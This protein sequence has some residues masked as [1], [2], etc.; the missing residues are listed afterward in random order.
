M[1]FKQNLGHIWSSN[2]PF[3]AFD[4]HVL[5]FSINANAKINCKREIIMEAQL[6]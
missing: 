2:E 3:N 4:S 1:N 5:N 6:A